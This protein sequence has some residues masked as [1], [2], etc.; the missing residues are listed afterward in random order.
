MVWNYADFNLVGYDPNIPSD[1]KLVIEIKGVRSSEVHMN[2]NI[3]LDE[4]L[5]E[6]S[7]SS[8]KSGI[9]GKTFEFEKR[10]YK[11]YDKIESQKNDIR[12]NLK[13]ETMPNQSINF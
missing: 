2:G 4:I 12:K 3:K 6:S 13:I 5:N 8:S 11:V 10:A 1:A 7:I 9:L